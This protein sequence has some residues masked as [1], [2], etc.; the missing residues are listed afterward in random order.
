MA[1]GR[2]RFGPLLPP[3]QQPQ[4]QPTLQS[5]PPGPAVVPL[6][7]A[8]E[9]MHTRLRIV[10][11]PANRCADVAK[12][13]QKGETGREAEGGCSNQRPEYETRRCKLTMSRVQMICS[14]ADDTCAM[15]H[16]PPYRNCGF[17]SGTLAACWNWMRGGVQQCTTTGENG[18]AGG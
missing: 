9:I 17:L 12:T 5:H 18:S 16:I 4:T 10:A 14:S 15:L 1:D 3:C 7:C 8:A 2:P 6:A 13:V 11:E